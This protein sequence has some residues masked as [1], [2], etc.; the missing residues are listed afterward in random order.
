MTTFLLFLFFFAAL[1]V[2]SG[3]FQQ[4]TLEMQRA[5]RVEYRFIPRT[6]YE[7]QM[8]ASAT[9]SAASRIFERPDPWIGGGRVTED[10]ARGGR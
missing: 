8:D 6:L 4:K 10:A 5:H 7:E 1:L 9:S 3:I 2:M